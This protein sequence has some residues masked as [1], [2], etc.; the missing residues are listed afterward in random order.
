MKKS[1]EDSLEAA[2]I[3]ATE[4][5]RLYK[6]SALRASLQ[7]APKSTYEQLLE[8]DAFHKANEEYRKTHPAAP[9]I[10]QPPREFKLMPPAALKLPEEVQHYE[11]GKPV[12]FYYPR[13]SIGRRAAWFHNWRV[14]YGDDGRGGELTDVVYSRDWR[15]SGAGAPDVEKFPDEYLMA[16]LTDVLSWQGGFSQKASSLYFSYSTMNRGEW[17]A[18]TERLLTD[19]RRNEE[20]VSPFNPPL[21]QSR[22]RIN[23]A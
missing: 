21:T 19:A 3:I 15:I 8:R 11:L 5:Q 9:K 12:Q 17:R 22:V 13:F 18:L 1:K 6:E 2:R 7:P 4:Q 16:V 10:V 20:F 14:S 23:N